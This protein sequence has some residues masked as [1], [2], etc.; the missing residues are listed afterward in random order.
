VI[1]LTKDFAAYLKQIVTID[2]N[3]KFEEGLE[4]F[5]REELK[6]NCLYQLFLV[7]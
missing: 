7:E 6:L 2:E 4:D 1:I 5:V 3:R